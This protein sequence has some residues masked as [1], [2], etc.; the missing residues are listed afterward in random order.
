MFFVVFCCCC[1]VLC[2]LCVHVSARVLCGCAI[3]YEY[4]LIIVV[5][6]YCAIDCFVLLFFFATKRARGRGARGEGE[7]VFL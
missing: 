2:A 7:G 1:G 3:L 6:Y 4:P 5:R